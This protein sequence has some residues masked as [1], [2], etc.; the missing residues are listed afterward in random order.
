MKAGSALMA[1]LILVPVLVLSIMA[2][3]C[4]NMSFVIK[5]LR[6]ELGEL[7]DQK[8]TLEEKV[9]E[10]SLELQKSGEKQVQL[11]S[12]LSRLEVSRRRFISGLSHDLRTPMTSIQGYVE[13]ILDGVIAGAEDQMKYLRLIHSKILGV[14]RMTQDL[15]DLARLESRQ[16]SLN[17]ETV[18]AGRLIA[19]VYEKYKLD[20]EAAGILFGLQTPPAGPEDPEES[21]CPCLS[22]DPGQLDRVF[23]ILI[24]NAIRRT[25]QGGTI[26]ISCAFGPPKTGGD[27]PEVLIALRDSGPSISPDALPH[28]FDHFNRQTGAGKPSGGSAGLSLTIAREIIELHGGRIRAES[29]Q[30]RGSTFLFTLP[31]VE[32][33]CP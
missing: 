17:L 2:L 33:A 16:V 28:L 15:F 18:K 30:G 25:P 8:G 1:L 23:A 19:G 9:G 14:N 7:K 13:A 20:V 10:L 3:R 5:G 11:N 6:R 4:K 26:V 31:A 27:G 24:F 21:P 29:H 32:T 12:R 22:V